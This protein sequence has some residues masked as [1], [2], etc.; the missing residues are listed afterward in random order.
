MTDDQQTAFDKLNA[1]QQKFVVKYF[2]G[3]VDLRSDRVTLDLTGAT[4][5]ENGEVG[6][7]PVTVSSSATP[8]CLKQTEYQ[9]WTATREAETGDAETFLLAMVEGQ[10]GGDLDTI[11]RVCLRFDTSAY[12]SPVSA[13][14]QIERTGQDNDPTSIF[15]AKCAFSARNP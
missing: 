10:I 9:D 3:K 8:R 6:L 1:R 11:N 14:F 7:D 4:G 5:D 12:P 2:A 13:V 15:L